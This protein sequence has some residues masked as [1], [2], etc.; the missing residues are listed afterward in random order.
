[1]RISDNNLADSVRL[2]GAQQSQAVGEG[3]RPN[4]TRGS[5]VEGDHVSLSGLAS[6]LAALDSASPERQAYLE[7]I[8]SLVETG[9]YSPDPVRMADG[10]INDA[11]RGGPIDAG[12][13]E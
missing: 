12:S 1:M 6:G 2:S 8:Q 7:R 4:A 9:R 13:A 3:K 11:L 10:I 5:G